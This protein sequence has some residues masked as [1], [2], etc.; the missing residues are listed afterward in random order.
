MKITIYIST[1]I[2]YNGH[3]AN[4][5]EILQQIKKEKKHVIRKY[6]EE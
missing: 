6:E 2:W 3:K 1:E 4:N 5:T